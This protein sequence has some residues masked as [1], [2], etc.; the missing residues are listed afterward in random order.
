[1]LLEQEYIVEDKAGRVRAR[2]RVRGRV[3]V[4][5]TPPLTP[6]LTLTRIPNAHQ[7]GDVQPQP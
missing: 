3:R 4:G 2:L 6:T 7:A 1:M 5:L